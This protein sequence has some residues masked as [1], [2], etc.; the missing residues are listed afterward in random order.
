MG[1]VVD[2]FAAVDKR[3][4]LH[5]GRK[6]V[7]VQLLD[8]GVNSFERLFR[9]VAFCSSTMPSTTSSLSTILPSSRWIASPNCPSRIFGPCATVGDVLHPQRCAAF[10]S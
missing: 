9:I 5:S 10:A 1:G 2:Q 8:F 4:D 7:I 6:N 3:N